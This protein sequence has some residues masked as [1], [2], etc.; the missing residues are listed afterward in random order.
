MSLTER[1]CGTSAA[2]TALCAC[3]AVATACQ[4]CAGCGEGH[5]VNWGGLGGAKRRGA[6]AL[7]LSAATG[8][9]VAVAAAGAVGPGRHRRPEA[10][11]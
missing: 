6:A 7:R 2:E 4:A 11:K 8:G 3:Q 5:A 10:A 9:A 1:P